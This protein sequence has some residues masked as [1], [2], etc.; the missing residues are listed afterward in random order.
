MSCKTLT[1]KERTFR[2]ISRA[3][4]FTMLTVA[5]ALVALPSATQAQS[6]WDLTFG[7]ALAV[8]TSDLADGWDLG[9][10]F[11]A[12]GTYWFQDRLGFRLETSV[13]FL[14]GDDGNSSASFPTAVP[15]VNLWHFGGG[16]EYS[17]T[18]RDSDGISVIVNGGGGLT[19]MKS[20]EFSIAG[21]LVAADTF[22]ETYGHLNGG[23]SFGYPL[24]DDLTIAVN[25]SL[26]VTFA[27][28]VDTNIPAFSGVDP[29][30]TAITFP[31]GI[32]LRFHL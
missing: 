6:T 21:S 22:S 18:D 30:D 1:N 16:L 27:D 14:S 31:V 28:E 17:V 9:V 19:Y 23:L 4:A 13:D 11:T 15:D 2:M 24:S 32:T 29:F 8:P 3:K 7:S 10:N 5:A 20:D 12:A 25:G 26:Y